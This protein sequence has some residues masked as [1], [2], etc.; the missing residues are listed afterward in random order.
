MKFISQETNGKD[1]EVFSFAGNAKE[2]RL[3][4]DL[5]RDYR[6]KTPLTMETMI[7]HNRMRLIEKRLADFF[8]FPHKKVRPIKDE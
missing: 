3:I 5:M 2:W 4:H 8:L 1:V 7:V 6:V